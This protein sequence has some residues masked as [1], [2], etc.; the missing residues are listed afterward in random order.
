[1]L[2]LGTQSH[3]ICQDEDE[4]WGRWRD[5]V[6]R[7]KSAF[8]PKR[9]VAPPL[10]PQNRRRRGGTVEDAVFVEDPQEAV[11]DAT[12][13]EDLPAPPVET[14]SEALEGEEIATPAEPTEPDIPQIS[15]EDAEAK[16]MEYQ[17]M[18]D[19]GLKP[20]EAKKEAA[21]M[22]YCSECYLPLHPDPNKEKLYI[23]LHALRYT[24][25]LG[26]FE[27]DMPVW[28]AK[29]WEWDRS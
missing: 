22:S 10:P 5:V 28:A 25:S 18:L 16:V 19:A 14:A 24:T 21:Q 4:D 17:A 2:T 23:F 26:C 20:E 3:V 6:F 8:V 27:T 12:P 7:T 11:T 1:M 29:G 9:V 15:Q 13:V